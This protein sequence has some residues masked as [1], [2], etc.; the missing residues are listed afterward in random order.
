MN[1]PK[2]HSSP[3]D[4]WYMNVEGVHYIF[5]FILISQAGW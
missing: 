2:A 1:E 4:V 3:L 5:V